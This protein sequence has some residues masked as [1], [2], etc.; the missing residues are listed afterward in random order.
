MTKTT[1]NRLAKK[2]K[3]TVSDR[4]GEIDSAMGQDWYSLTL[5]W[6]LASGLNPK[7]AHE[8]ASYIRYETEL[9]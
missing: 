7:D 6:A 1:R 3:E 4:Y 5:G 2:F 8:F 9:G